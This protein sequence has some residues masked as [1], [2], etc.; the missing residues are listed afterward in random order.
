MRVKKFNKILSKKTIVKVKGKGQRS[1][2]KDRTFALFNFGTLPSEDLNDTL[3]FLHWS[4]VTPNVQT[5][6][7]SN[8]K[9][10]PSVRR[11]LQASDGHSKRQTATPSG[12]TATPSGWTATP[13]GWTATPSVRRPLQA[14]DGHSKRSDDNF[15]RPYGYTK[16]SDGHSKLS[17]GP[18]K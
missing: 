15:K 8:Q 1:M 16:K 7:P 5:A 11:L 6:T 12:W 10:T 18:I 17:G 13:S 14:S 2:I 4:Q 3:L 9:A